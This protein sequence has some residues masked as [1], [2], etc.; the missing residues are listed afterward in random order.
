MVETPNYIT[1]VWTL[2]LFINFSYELGYVFLLRVDPLPAQQ[3]NHTQVRACA[4]CVASKPLNL[5]VQPFRR[6]VNNSHVIKHMCVCVS[7][8]WFLHP[9]DWEQKP[10][11]H[12]G[13]I[14]WDYIMSPP[15]KQQHQ[16]GEGR[17]TLWFLMSW[18]MKPLLRWWWSSESTYTWCTWNDD[19]HWTWNLTRCSEDFCALQAYGFHAI[20]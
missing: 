10:W 4:T 13:G 7:Q 17:R 9:K 8:N 2:A 15:D 20:W 19:W 6:T 3:I 11:K 18:A 1:L 14:W 16:E 12:I 5:F